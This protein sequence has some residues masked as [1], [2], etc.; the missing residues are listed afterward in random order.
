MSQ[1]YES[2]MAASLFLVD[3]NFLQAKLEIQVNSL[4]Q[5][6]LIT[7]QISKV[8]KN[9]HKACAWNQPRSGK[10]CTGLISA[11]FA[12]QGALSTP[13]YV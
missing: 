2:K 12:S 7:G 6:S 9:D 13:T 8:R 1:A 11:S 10:I 4:S 5:S 3:A